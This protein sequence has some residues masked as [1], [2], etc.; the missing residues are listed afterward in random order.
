MRIIK[1]GGSVLRHTHDFEAM[2]SI[3]RAIGEEQA[4]VIVSALAGTTR[5]LER[6]TLQAQNGKDATALEI[7]NATLH[8]HQELATHLFSTQHSTDSLNEV[9]EECRIRIGNFLR[10]I[11]ITRELTP[12]TLD[13]VL[14]FGEYMG[15][16]LVRLYLRE[17]GLMIGCVESPHIIVTD[18]HHGSAL[19][20][21]D[22]TLARIERVLR[23]EFAQTNI[24]LMQGFVARSES[25]EITTMGKESSNLSATLMGELLNAREVIIYTDV[26]GIRTADPKIVSASKP[27]PSLTYSQAYRAAVNGVKLLYP[28]MIEPLR[29]SGIP[30]LFRSLH[31]PE[32]NATVIGKR[33]ED[34]PHPMITTREGV[35][36]LRLSFQT[37]EAREQARD[38]IARIY[39]DPSVIINIA[40]FPDAIAVVATH[41]RL[42]HISSLIPE[43]CSAYYLQGYTL[44]TLINAPENLMKV[45]DDSFVE[46]LRD[47]G[48]IA[49]DIGFEES[50]MR[51]LVPQPTAQGIVQ[52]LH[53]AVVR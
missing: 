38:I 17:Q 3:L 5:S 42:L 30:L 48:A 31:N 6:A 29:R 11:A 34:L 15:L 22:K 43:D 46:H 25:G 49:L 7:L 26:E 45:L 35:N 52:Q 50:S 53:A 9:L 37:S 32:S 13:M 20:L 1:F 39:P 41:S 40:E 14:S 18:E 27:V 44:I 8:E 10:G 33:A 36:L 2:A 4:L 51:L 21:R 12:R 16:H 28:T 24:I 23:P 47:S 19:P